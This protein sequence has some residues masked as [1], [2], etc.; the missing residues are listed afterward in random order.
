MKASWGGNDCAINS[1]TDLTAVVDAVLTS[2]QPSMVFLEAPNGNVLVFGVGLDESVL[3]FVEPDGRSFHSIGKVDRR[4]LLVFLCRDQLEDF[5]GEMAVPTR[6]A[7]AAAEQFVSNHQRPP[8][9]RWEP[10][11]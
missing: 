6:D 8:A 7:L 9:V 3:T 11:W 1:R 10:D 2:A 5:M 4:D